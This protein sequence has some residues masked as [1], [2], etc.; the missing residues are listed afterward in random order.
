MNEY[1]QIIPDRETAER[2][3]TAL[4]RGILRREPD[5][6]GFRRFVEAVLSGRSAASIAE[7]FISNGEFTYPLKMYVSPGHFYS[8]IVNP[9]VADRH[10]RQLETAPTPH[11]VAG[12]TIDRVEMVK[13]WR[14]LLPFLSTAPFQ[15][16]VSPPLHYAFINPSYS[17]GDGSILHAMLRHYK[18]RRFIEI[19]SGWSSACTIDTVERFLS[20]IGRAHV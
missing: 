2:F 3:V 1:S 17:W 5:Q 9:A 20:Q 11:S 6:D 7:Q 14:T 8:P 10:L 19:G 18:P 15:D 13:L 12:I 4:Y 16:N